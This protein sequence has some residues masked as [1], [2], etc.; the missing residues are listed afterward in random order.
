MIHLHSYTRS[1]N[2]GDAI[3]SVAMLHCITSIWQG[4]LVVGWMDRDHPDPRQ[5]H[6]PK[7][8]VNG[9]LDKRWNPA[10]THYE[11][12]GVHCAD[13]D[14]ALTAHTLAGESPIGAR[15]PW[16]DASMIGLNHA[17][18]MIG[19]ATLT[20]PR[21]YGV[22]N[23]PGIAVDCSHDDASVFTTHELRDDISWELQIAQARQQLEF[24]KVASAVYTS[25]LH[26]LL[27]CIAMGTP[28]VLTEIKCAR[29]FGL[30]RSMGVEIG[31]EPRTYDPSM[32]A[33]LF[34]A[35]T[36]RAVSRLTTI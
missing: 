8:L 10:G 34:R 7:V 24:Y 23:G 3:Q 32:L 19:C 14:T 31:G 29:R 21:Y 22:R 9:F 26:V 5:P 36:M 30:V 1:G 2:L 27:P 16:T 35:W 15:D 4:G 33:D 17:G 12:C 6:A 20:L 28:V 11:F 13:R 18:Q 25:R